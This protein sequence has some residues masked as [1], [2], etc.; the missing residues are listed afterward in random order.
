[1]SRRTVKISS[2]ELLDLLAGRRTIRELN[3]AHGWGAVASLGR[4]MPSP[5]SRSLEEGRMIK[6]IEVVRAADD[7]DDWVTI[8][9]GDPDPAI[10]PFVVK[11]SPSS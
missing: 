5:F 1:M 6:R 8:E 10:A 3:E 7:D 11:S 4:T 2:R 9:F